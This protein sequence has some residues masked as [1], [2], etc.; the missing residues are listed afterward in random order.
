[1]IAFFR[2]GLPSLKPS[3]RNPLMLKALLQHPLTRGLDIDDPRTT[4]LRRRIIAEKPFLRQIY[5][6]W[7]K[8]IATALPPVPGA[9]LE[10]GSGAGFMAQRVPDLIAT[11]I[12][13][14]PSLDVVADAHRL[15][16][17]SGSLRAIVM[18]NVF[19][20]LA[21]P[22]RFLAEATRCVR[23]GGSLIMIEPWVTPWSRVIYSRL[24]HEPFV[25]DAT[26][27]EFPPSGPLSGANGALPWIVFQRDRDGLAR[28]FPGWELRSVAPQMPFRYLLSGGVSLRSLMPGWCFGLWRAA[29]ALLQPWMGH[30]AMFACIVL[31]R[32]SL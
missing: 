12:I 1:M 15:P 31:V 4:M 23:C 27:W 16:F 20:H 10:L 21:E 29:E 3:L 17:A 26:T 28:A 11:D 6:E 30:L 9:V 8:A 32:G 22:R 5:Q 7:Y 24:H 2:E 18:T 25:P 14:C 13:A 19:H